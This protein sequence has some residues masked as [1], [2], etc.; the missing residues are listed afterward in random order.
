MFALSMLAAVPNAFG[1]MEFDAINTRHPPDGTDFFT[2]PVYK[3]HDG[4]I[5]VP[6]GLGWGVELRPGLLKDAI[7]Q[8]STK[9][10]R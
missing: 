8:T 5:S 1:H 10:S 9:Y 3:I 7:N 4:A 2:Q 6:A